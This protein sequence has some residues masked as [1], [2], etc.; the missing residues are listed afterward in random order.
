MLFNKSFLVNTL[1]ILI[2]AVLA[3]KVNV[4]GMDNCS[5]CGAPFQHEEGLCSCNDTFCSLC[6]ECEKGCG[7]DCKEEVLAAVV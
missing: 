1:Q 5:K 3:L 4:R 7:C 6:C 2:R